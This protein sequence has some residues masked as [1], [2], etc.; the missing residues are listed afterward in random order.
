MPVG[1]AL[2]GS[3]KEPANLTGVLDLKRL[4]IETGQPW[5]RTVQF[6]AHAPLREWWCSKQDANKKPRKPRKWQ[7]LVE[8]DGVSKDN[9]RD[10]WKFIDQNCSHA[11]GFS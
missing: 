1:W 4:A 11:D 2:V 7:A 10:I 3:E 9:L 8:I 5:A 6:T